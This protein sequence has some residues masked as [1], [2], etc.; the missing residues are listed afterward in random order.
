MLS[1]DTLKLIQDSAEEILNP[2]GF[3]LVEFKYM[4]SNDNIILRFLADRTEG[5]ISLDECSDLNKRI[6][7]L[8]D[9]RNIL[10]N[11]YTLEV[12]SPGLD[13]S[14]TSP[15]DFKRNLDKNMHLFLNSQHSGKVELEGKL[16][17]LNDEGLVIVDKNNKE[18]T[19]MF[20]E[21]NRAK[22]VIL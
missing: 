19:V 9:E 4:Q 13:R 12:S 6:G 8:L 14:L 10:S 22:Q 7:Q 21:I 20:S 15:K 17:R 2:L 5:G 16:I 1:K 3:D 18:E 11:R